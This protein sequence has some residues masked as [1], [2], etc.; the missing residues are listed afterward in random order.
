MRAVA[1]PVFFLLLV[2]L[3]FRIHGDYGTHFDDPN[4]RYLA[5]V[6][7]RYV[8][9]TLIPS[10]VPEQAKTLP[11]LHE[12]VD[13]D[14]GVGVE[15]PLLAIE[16]L[17]GVRDTRDIYV[18]RHLLL[19]LLGVA[20]TYAVY[21]MA[22]RRFLDWRIGLL[23]ALLFVVSPR[24]FADSFYNSKD[25][26]FLAVFAI[27]LATTVAFVLRP[28]PATAL[29]NAL[30]TGLAVDVRLVALVLPL[31]ATALLAVRLLKREVPLARTV[32]AHA[33][34]LLLAALVAIALWPFLW[35]DPI[36]NFA[37]AFESMSKFRWTLNNIYMGELVHSSKLPWH[38]IPVW[39]GITTP[40]LY[41]ALFIVGVAAILWAI[42]RRG[43]GLWRDERELQDILFLG[44]L[45]S[46][47]AAAIVMQSILYDGW[48]QMF[49]IYAP[50]MLIAMRGWMLFWNV[51]PGRALVR[52]AL[53]A[54]TA[55]SVA[56]TA[57][58][59]IR[60]HPLQNV[61][62]NALAGSDLRTR[63]E[64]DYWGMANHLALDYILR[65]D[66]SPVIYVRTDAVTPVYSAFNIMKAK[67]RARLRF[68]DG[69]KRPEY[70]VTNYRFTNVG[71]NPDQSDARYLEDYTPFWKL[72]IDGEVI[73]AVFKLKDPAP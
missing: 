50:F 14:Y 46:P 28:A 40:L 31:G 1:P 24:T 23:A 33:L 36:G 5:Q 30:A 49:F 27:A 16:I 8:L 26:A 69:T 57:A 19:F 34:Y 4:G 54:A 20:G 32:A 37:Y 21:W 45:V 12:Y 25:G 13:R 42:L 72:E 71:D 6:T 41:L 61:Y 56:L 62:F 9:E 18:F 60:V 48:R 70:L 29:F 15:L 58:W 51:V 38:Y 47:A 10:R 17:A 3:G 52:P 65:H 7:S 53:G 64:L 44:V 59:M 66:D 55:L 2:L 73:L 43:F 68:G 63:W 11:P 35:T 67:D 39:I 22:A